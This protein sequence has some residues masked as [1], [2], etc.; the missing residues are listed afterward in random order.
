MSEQH[1][2]SVGWRKLPLA[3]PP[4]SIP[5]YWGAQPPV[6]VTSSAPSTWR[7]G[8]APAEFSLWVRKPPSEYHRVET[9]YD[10]L[11]PWLA[12]DKLLPLASAATEQRAPTDWTTEA[13]GGVHTAQR[14]QLGFCKSVVEAVRYKCVQPRPS[15][16]KLVPT[17]GV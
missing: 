11:L 5:V 7:A 12:G 15:G 4:C 8:L 3:P 10:V 1:Y 14:S 16:K 2:S 9:I 6:Y 17:V 13:L